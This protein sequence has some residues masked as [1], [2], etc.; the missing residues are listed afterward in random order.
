M[1]K[2]FAVVLSAFLCCAFLSCSGGTDII[3]LSGSDYA[4]D[5]VFVDELLVDPDDN[6]VKSTASLLSA[7]ESSASETPA[8][9]SSNSSG[10]SSTSSTSIDESSVESSGES[11]TDENTENGSSAAGTELPSETVL[12]T[13]S[14]P[15]SAAPFAEQKATISFDKNIPDAF[16]SMESVSATVGTS[17][18]LG[19]NSFQHPVLS[20]AGWNTQADGS[21]ESFSD[22]DCVSVSCDVVLYAQW[23]FSFHNKPVLLPA[24]TDGS[25]GTGARYVMFGDFPQTI[26]AGDV[27][28]DETRS[29]VSGLYTYYAGS[30]GFYY[31][32]WQE[33]PCNRDGA[34]NVYSDG[35]VP[36][37]NNVSYFKVEPI[38]WRVLD[39]NYEETGKYLLFSEKLLVGGI[40]F[41]ACAT[42]DGDIAVTIGSDEVYSNNYKYST[43]RAYLNGEC[44]PCDTLNSKFLK[45]LGEKKSDAGFLQSAFFEEGRARIA[46]VTVDNSLSSCNASVGN[47]KPE[48]ICPDTEDKIFLLSYRDIV[49]CEYGFPSSEG[50][51][52]ERLRTNTDFA[53]A[54]GSKTQT[55]DASLGAG[56]WYYLRSPSMTSSSV[57]ISDVNHNGAI[58][59]CN[60]NK[61][62]DYSGIAPALVVSVDD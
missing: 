61:W 24:G 33:N 62:M 8:S 20:F 14:L 19:K 4:N 46:T 60:T 52:S 34:E 7:N 32:K 16:G 13:A 30:D 1:K 40:P 48:Y 47:E 17:C 21:G 37:K 56:G 53:L 11:A 41:R 3:E 44:E 18:A 50:K 10:N 28:V 45:D 43:I 12:V 6:L 15:N 54:R 31:A 55:L 29:V 59:V 51:C 2:V 39:D 9:Q 23:S 27:T 57:K 58:A 49:S 5:S 35:S 25:A 22:E 26:K 42:A 36:V 38:K